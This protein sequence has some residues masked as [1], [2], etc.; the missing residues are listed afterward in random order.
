M[1]DATAP[2]S[3]DIDLMRAAI[4]AAAHVRTSTAPNPWV[5]AVVASADGSVIASGAT[6]P[7]GAGAAAVPAS[8]GLP[9]ARHFGSPPSST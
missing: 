9:S 3:R 6:S 7:P 8:T 5:G 1:V 4:A 2:G